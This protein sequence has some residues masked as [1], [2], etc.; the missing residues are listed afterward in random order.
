MRRNQI[1]ASRSAQ[2]K[3]EEEWIPINDLLCEMATIG[4]P[5]IDGV[6]YKISIHGVNARD[7]STPHIHLDR[8][9]DP[10]RKLF[11]FEISLVDMLQ[12]G[13]PVLILQKDAKNNIDRKDKKLC[14]WGGYASLRKG[15][16]S[17]LESEPDDPAAPKGARTNLESLIISWNRECGPDPNRMANYLQEQ[18]VAVLPKYREYFPTLYPSAKSK[19]N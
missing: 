13:E 3:V 6:E 9:D 8:A 17:F 12:S 10:D 18:G 11:Q 4:W 2:S 1:N 15:V 5:N 19:G 16:V 14:S 7:R